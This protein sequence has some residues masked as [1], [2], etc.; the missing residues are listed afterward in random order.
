MGGTCNKHWTRK[1]YKILIRESERKRPL[2]LIGVDK[3]MILK[4]TLNI[5]MYSE[6]MWRFWL[7]ALVNMAVNFQVP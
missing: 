6:F 3:R 2:W 4:W 7:R 1:T 5:R